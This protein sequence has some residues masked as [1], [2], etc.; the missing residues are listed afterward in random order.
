[1]NGMQSIGHRYKY[2]YLLVNAKWRRQSSIQK[3]VNLRH[4]A[5]KRA[6]TFV[7]WTVAT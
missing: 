4:Y 2:T 7:F 6:G 3:N 1:M 5:Q